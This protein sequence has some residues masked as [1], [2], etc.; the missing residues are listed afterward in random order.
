MIQAALLTVLLVTG[1]GLALLALF[2]LGPRWAWARWAL[3]APAGWA[4][5][6]LAT[7]GLYLS[8]HPVRA[9][10]GILPWAMATAALVVLLF[11]W[12]RLRPSS[13]QGMRRLSF[14]ALGQGAV[15]L[16]LVLPPLIGGMNFGVYRGNYGDAANYNA[17]AISA[18][19]HSI[20]ELEHAS[21]QS[22]ADEHPSLVLVKEFLLHDRLATGA[23]LSQMARLGGVSVVEVNYL[24]GALALAFG[25]G[26]FFFAALLGGLSARRACALAA[27]LS[28]GFWAMSPL[29]LNATGILHAWPLFS[30][31]L[32]ALTLL[33]RAGAGVLLTLSVAAQCLVYP[34]YLPVLGGGTVLWLL[35]M[36]WARPAWLGPR[37]KALGWVALALGAFLGLGGW[38][39]LRHLVFNVTGTASAGSEVNWHFNHYA[40]LT[41]R[42]QPWRIVPGFWGLQPL[43]HL[44]PLY[45]PA[46]LALCGAY[47]GAWAWALR[48]KERFAGP[49]TVFAWAG[50]AGL[51][52]ALALGAQWK[53]FAVCRVLTFSFPCALLGLIP[54]LRQP[55]PQGRWVRPLVDAWIGVQL[56]YALVLVAWAI[57]GRGNAPEYPDPR[58]YFFKQVDYDWSGLRQALRASNV[59]SLAIDI[60]TDW[61]DEFA[62]QYFAEFGVWRATPM[63]IHAGPRTDGL[64]MTRPQ[65]LDAVLVEK[66]LY[67]RGLGAGTL[68]AETA[69]L[70]VYRLAPGQGFRAA[71]LVREKP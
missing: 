45:L 71:P 17:L 21:L 42:T 10:S 6:S 3:A 31:S 52:V 59:K 26:P 57:T 29:E 63:R 30:L 62:E 48:K 20:A 7:A 39:V 66:K 56:L 35:A 9:W 55:A 13:P 25:F 36:A 22:L 49:G 65:R 24:L 14:F 16:L 11:R 5:F 54:L 33:P 43:Y 67:P 40:W 8:G 41:D 34:F 27:A 18:D 58:H 19:R 15:L 2:E 64:A 46:G 38:S 51:A 32:A 28:C 4:A 61:A 60:R 44:K 23:M 50:V 70:S 53:L 1:M 69:E 12:R 37:L 47:A 68:L